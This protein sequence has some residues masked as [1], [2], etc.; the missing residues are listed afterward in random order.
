MNNTKGQ[1]LSIIILV[2]T[3]LSIILIALVTLYV[4][5]APL[6][7]FSTAM[8]SSSPEA[9]TRIDYLNNTFTGL[10]DDVI[11]LILFL[12]VL[13]LFISAFLVDVHPAFLVLYIGACFFL[14]LF[15]PT[16]VNSIQT[17]WDTSA[18]A[19]TTNEMPMVDYVLNNFNVIL[20]G[21]V[22]LSGILMYAKIKLFSTGNG[23]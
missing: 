8:N 16:A 23:V 21:I 9:S 4:V 19:T 5:K 13:L 10:W 2:G 20:L 18:F 22:I 17:I 3:L 11:M 14:F 1:A 15:A 12:N 6:D 7:R